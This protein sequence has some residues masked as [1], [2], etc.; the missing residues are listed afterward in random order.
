MTYTIVLIIGAVVGGLVVANNPTLADKL[1][2][3]RRKAAEKAK[4]KV[5][6]LKK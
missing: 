2:F 5:E 3:L 4:A 6:E 1:N